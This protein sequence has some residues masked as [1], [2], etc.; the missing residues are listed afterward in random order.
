MFSFQSEMIQQVNICNAVLE[1]S[2]R[3]PASHLWES[4][5]LITDLFAPQFFFEFQELEAEVCPSTAES[6]PQQMHLL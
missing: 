5:Q 6:S 1:T 2:R 4:W 3:F